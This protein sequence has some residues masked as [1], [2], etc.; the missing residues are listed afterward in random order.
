[1]NISNESETT[2]LGI[3]VVSFLL[4][5]WLYDS[6]RLRRAWKEDRDLINDFIDTVI[7]GGKKE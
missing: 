2:I 6:I 7:H 1:M 3:I 4:I 5:A